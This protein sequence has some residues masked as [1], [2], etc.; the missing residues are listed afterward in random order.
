MTPKQKQRE[1]TRKQVF[2]LRLLGFNRAQVAEQ[3]NLSIVTVDRYYYR[4]LKLARPNLPDKEEFIRELNAAQEKRI[5]ELWSTVMDKG[6]ERIDR[7][8]ALHE[9]REEESLLIRKGQ[10]SGILPKEGP[11]ALF[12]QN[13][14]NNVVNKKYTLADAFKEVYGD[15]D[16]NISK[17]A[18]QQVSIEYSEKEE[19]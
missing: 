1:K 18:S 16:K 15:L 13:I 12:Q 8:R 2:Q 14:Q 6:A 3:M 11:L 19:E 10:L 5:R 4:E 9:L 17:K 7:I